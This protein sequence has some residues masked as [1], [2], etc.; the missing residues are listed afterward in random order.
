MVSVFLIC[1][2]D[3]WLTMYAIENLLQKSS[4]VELELLVIVNGKDKRII[5]YLSELIESKRFVNLITVGVVENKDTLEEL[6]LESKGEYICLFKPFILVNE[7][8]LMDLVY[9]NYNI[10]NSGLSAIYYGINT[11][12][13]KPLIAQNDDF[14]N[15]WQ[16]NENVVHGITLFHKTSLQQPIYQEQEIIDYF[17][18]NGYLNYYIPTQNSIKIK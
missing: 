8:W 17:T 16:P 7:N 6:F 13:F 12:K 4:G 14:I 9:H 11:N 3:Y 5:D 2:N 1:N 15:V 10:Q 18:K